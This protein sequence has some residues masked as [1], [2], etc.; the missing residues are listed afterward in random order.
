MKSIKY[1]DLYVLKCYECNKVFRTDN[2]YAKLCPECKDFRKP[3][4]KS[5][6]KKEAQKPLTVAEVLHISSVYSKVKHKYINYGEMVSII[7]RNADHCVCCGEVVPEGRHVCPNCEKA[8][9]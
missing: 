3:C 2:P 5:R 6:K 7:S 8:V 1:S 9:K 4:K